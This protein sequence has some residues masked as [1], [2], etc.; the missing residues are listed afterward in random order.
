MGKGRVL[1]GYPAVSL[2]M[3]VFDES[4]KA[5]ASHVVTLV[6]WEEKW[7]VEDAFFNLSYADEN[8]DIL[9]VREI[10]R[11]VDGGVWG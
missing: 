1:L 2:D 5:I 11:K 9:D 6:L 7:I 8:E 3:A 10:K 4:G